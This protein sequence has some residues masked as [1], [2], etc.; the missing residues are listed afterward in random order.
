MYKARG[1]TLIE[2]M[3]TVAII[4]ILA[5]IAYPSYT[6]YTIRA[7]RAAAQ[8]HMLDIA[9]REQ[10]FFLD[11][12]SYA[13]TAAALNVTTPDSVSKFYTITIAVSNGPPP[14]YTITAIPKSGTVQA[15]DG[16]LTLDNT[17]QKTPSSKW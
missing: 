5:A 9:Q 16:N 8:S 10:Q 6:S 15:S 2:L 4:G 13:N 7:N 14:T 1:F 3:I 17:G 12:R 11:N